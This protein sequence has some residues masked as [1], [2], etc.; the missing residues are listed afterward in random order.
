MKRS[1]LP[2]LSLLAAGLTLLAAGGCKRGSSAAA[3]TPNTPA[4]TLAAGVGSEPIQA[5]PDKD[6]YKVTADTTGVFRYS[7]LQA[8]GSDF[9]LKKNARVTMINRG[10]G[11]SQIKAEDGQTGYVGTQDIAQLA[12]SEIQQEDAATLQAAQAAA[13][14]QLAAA[15]LPT[16][17]APV[18]T[19]NGKKSSAVQRSYT[20]PS[21]ADADTRLPDA[22]TRPKA[23]PAS[24][25]GVNF[26]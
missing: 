14:A 12:P 8:S 18:T 26:R 15:G 6:R 17:N 19:V 25:P 10:R 5:V 20:I 22:D 13:G 24:S 4:A 3:T 2:F 1:P 7:P 23:T 16:N 11:F 21:A 9:D